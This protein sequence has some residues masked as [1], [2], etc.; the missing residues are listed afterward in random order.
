MKNW[1]HA[2]VGPDTPLRQAL[3]VIDRLGSQMVLVVNADR[4]LLGTLSDGDARRGLLRGLSLSDPVSAA[5][6]RE[7]TC[8]V[9]GQSRPAM[10]A[11]MRRLGLHQLPLVNAARQ[12]I[13]FEIASG[14]GSFESVVTTRLL[15]VKYFFDTF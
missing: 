4:V 12:V 5:M 14:R 15:V 7:P 3:E 1:E 2:L 10:L 11:L 9:E 6:Q 8:A 13:G